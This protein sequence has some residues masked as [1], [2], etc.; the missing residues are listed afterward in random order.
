M[1]ATSRWTSLSY[2]DGA[3]D[4]TCYGY[5]PWH[6]RYVGRETAQAIHDSGATA[7]EWLLSHPAETPDG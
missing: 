3:E 1:A 5:E 6:L 4:R 7:R 2:P